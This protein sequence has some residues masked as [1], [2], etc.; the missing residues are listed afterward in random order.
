[1]KTTPPTTSFSPTLARLL[2]APERV[3]SGMRNNSGKVH[4]NGEITIT[5][6]SVNS[7]NKMDFAMGN[8]MVNISIL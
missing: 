3:I 4:N 7:G 2:T 5:P 8:A 6:I 1:M